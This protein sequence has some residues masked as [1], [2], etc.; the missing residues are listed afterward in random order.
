MVHQSSLTFPPPPSE[1]PADWERRRAEAQSP[2]EEEEDEEGL[3]SL[4]FFISFWPK[5]ASVVLLRGL[6]SEKPDDMNLSFHIRV[7]FSF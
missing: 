4:S 7:F 3:S 2:E 1:L 5:W 6:T